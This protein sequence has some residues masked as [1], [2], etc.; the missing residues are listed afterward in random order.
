M[1]TTKSTLNETGLEVKDSTGSQDEV[2]LKAGYDEVTG[3]TIVK[4]K[5]MTVEKYLTIGKYSRIE[6]YEDEKLGPGTGI[7]NL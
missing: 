3:E 5:N 1:P 2:L 4:S 7:F 6:D